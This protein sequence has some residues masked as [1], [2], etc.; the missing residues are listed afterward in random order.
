MKS[1]KRCPLAY[2][3]LLADTGSIDSYGL[4]ACKQ[5]ACAWW[6]NDAGRCG[7]VPAFTTQVIEQYSQVPPVS[8]VYYR[9]EDDDAE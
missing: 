7:V 8:T 6:S 3:G 4:T 9:R 5:E 2:A 1:D